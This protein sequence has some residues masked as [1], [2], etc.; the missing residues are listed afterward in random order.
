MIRRAP[1][2]RPTLTGRLSRLMVSR[3]QDVP[4]ESVKVDIVMDGSVAPVSDEA[5]P[6]SIVLGRARSVARAPRSM[7]YMHVSDLIGKCIRKI[8]LVE[9]SEAVLAP[10]S[11]NYNDALTFAQ[12]EAIHTVIKQ[13][14][15][16]GSPSEVWGRWSCLCG[17]KATKLPCL[18]S[19]APKDTCSACRTPVDRYRE[20][21]VKDKEYMITGSPDLILYAPRLKALHVTELK[22][23][24]HDAW[25]ELLRPQPDHILQTVFYWHLMH[26]QG[27]R[28][29]D[30]VSIL[31]ATK[32]WMFSGS[33]F[34]EFMVNP[35]D[36]VHRLKPL[37]DDALAIKEARKGGNLPVRTCASPQSPD[38]KKCEMCSLCFGAT[39][40]NVV[41]VS[42]KS[43]SRR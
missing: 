36:H 40:A 2:T 19:Q 21:E 12:G 41:K 9:R 1:K 32:G 29:T 15:A 25:K 7:E 24:S 8:A 6:L 14:A 18:L 35:Q 31:Y 13:R 33:P 30:K 16:G 37:I 4:Q 39:S 11:L 22:S 27:Y 23:I 26:R 43:A 42:V 3:G 10:Q 5:E 34:K 28:L 17:T 20:I 38:A